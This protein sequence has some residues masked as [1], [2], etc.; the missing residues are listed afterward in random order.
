MNFDNA[1]IYCRSSKDGLATRNSIYLKFI[2]DTVIQA[3]N[4]PAIQKMNFD[5]LVDLIV[6]DSRQSVLTSNWDEYG[7]DGVSWF[8]GNC[9]DIIT[10]AR[11]EYVNDYDKLFKASF[12][13]YFQ[14][15]KP[16]DD[17]DK[18]FNNNK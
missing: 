14:G 9:V 18:Y 11:I 2:Q 1:E 7:L 3:K 10:Q 4:N 15:R 17:F 8:I 6:R 13:R 16:M 12:N 5:E